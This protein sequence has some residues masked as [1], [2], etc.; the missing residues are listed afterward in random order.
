MSKDCFLYSA[1]QPYRT[2][3]KEDEEAA[4]KR[5]S[6]IPFAEIE[7]ANRSLFDCTGAPPTPDGNQTILDK[8]I[9]WRFQ[10][11]KWRAAA[12]TATRKSSGRAKRKS[13][14]RPKK[15]GEKKRTIP[16]HEG[17]EK[18]ETSKRYRELRDP[19]LAHLGTI[20]EHENDDAPEWNGVEWVR[21]EGRPP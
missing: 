21:V 5:F 16:T 15:L 13:E 6:E 8:I 3:E 20:G 9:F 4:A 11:A 7:N 10:R 2:G 18:R 14:W 19:R 17:D 12:A 1:G